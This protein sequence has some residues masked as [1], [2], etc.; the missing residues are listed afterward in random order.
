MAMNRALNDKAIDDNLLDDVNGGVKVPVLS[1]LMMTDDTSA[2]LVHPLAG[3]K[4]EYTAS[5]LLAGSPLDPVS[6]GLAGNP[7]VPASGEG[8]NILK[9]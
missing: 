3:N 8:L 9:C 5:H 1:N 6:R 2:D 7:K 4:N